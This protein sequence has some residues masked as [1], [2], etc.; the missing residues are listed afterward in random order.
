MSSQIHPGLLLLI[1]KKLS[2]ATSSENESD[3][4]NPSLKND[5]L[6]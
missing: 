1:D 4:I 2:E 5:I 3:Y 6:V